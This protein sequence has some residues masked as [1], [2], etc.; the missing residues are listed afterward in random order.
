MESAIDRGVTFL[1]ECASGRKEDDYLA[2]RTGAAALAGLT[3]LS[4]GVKPDD[5]AV[6]KLAARVRTSADLGEA[7]TYDI[8]LGILFLDRLLEVGD[9]GD[10]ED[11]ERIRMLALRLMAGQN[12]SGGWS[13]T[14]PVLS[15]KAEKEFS[16][17]LKR[18][19]RP[20]DH[21]ALTKN[22]SATERS[23]T[24]E[25]PAAIDRDKLP[26]GL[27]KAAVLFVEPSRQ[28]DLSSND[29]NSNTQFALLAVWAAK[30]HGLP[31][32]RTLA[33][34]EARFRASQFPEGYWSYHIKPQWVQSDSMTCAGLLGLA[35]G[36]GT[37]AMDAKSQEPD[38]AIARGLQFLARGIGKP[39]KGQ[40]PR[41]GAR[42]TLISADSIGDLYYLWCL[43]RVAV[44][45]DLQTFGDKEWYP[46][47]AEII[48]KSQ[49]EDGSWSDVWHGVPDT[50]FALL[51][52][53]R[54]NVAQDLTGE[55][56]KL[57]NLIDRGAIRKK[58]E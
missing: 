20:I 27:R 43:E 24:P 5:P 3:L 58:D 49:K 46:W 36:R 10:A 34:V 2:K 54:T 8:S 26:P 15:D 7:G 51:F 56:R 12:E 40:I 52:L 9:R 50:C 14:C 47:G 48:V 55:L 53:K 45:Y 39:Y 21:A 38:A 32:D 23:T 42:G 41:H 22:D 37:F 17:L 44:A 19:P 29:D 11:R 57:E 16:E 33:L 13:Y 4:C 28:L 18:L 35:V 6:Q 31:A 25:K 1:K 30:K